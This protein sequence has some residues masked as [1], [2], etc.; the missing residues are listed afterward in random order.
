MSIM[1]TVLG[2]IYSTIAFT[3]ALLLVVVL[4]LFLVGYGLYMLEQTLSDG[5]EQGDEYLEMK[6]EVLPLGQ[7][8]VARK[9]YT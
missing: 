7:L 1:G 3:P 8:M 4:D 2:R 9:G 6:R 5:R